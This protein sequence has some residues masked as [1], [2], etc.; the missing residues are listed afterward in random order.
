MLPHMK[1]AQ[2]LS[3]GM[4]LLM[5]ALSAGARTMRE[6]AL[7]SPS[8]KRPLPVAVRS[9]VI[10]LSGLDQVKARFNSDAGKI[11]LVVLVSP[12]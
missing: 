3:C 6:D 1:I 9:E 12:T 2:R 7:R 4:L 5:I 8:P 11:R 10:P